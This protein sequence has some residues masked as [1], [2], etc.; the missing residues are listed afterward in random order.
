MQNSRTFLIAS[1]VLFLLV[2]FAAMSLPILFTAII[3]KAVAIFILASGVISLVMAI[4]GKQKSY[5]LLEMLSG[6]IRIAAGVVLLSCLKS[7]AL[8]ITMAFAIY[9][10]VEG[11][12]VIATSLRMRTTPGWVWTLFSGVAALVLGLLVYLG[13]PTSSFSVLGF[14][15]G[16]NL[17]LKGAA[18]IALGITH[19]SS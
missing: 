4:A 18:Q 10:A 7:S 13:W 11:M 12:F 9:L 2:G 16:I 3:V 19:R 8:V 6:I 15:L 1:G 14:F 5:R 17:V